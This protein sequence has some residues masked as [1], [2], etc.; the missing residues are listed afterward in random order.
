MCDDQR[1]VVARYRPGAFFGEVPLLLDVPYIL[2]ARGSGLKADRFSRG[3]LLGLA[4]VM[5]LDCRRNFSGDSSAAAEPGGIQP[6]TRKTRFPWTHVRGFGARTKQS[7]ARSRVAVY[8]GEVIQTIQGVAHEL[9]QTLRE[10][11]GTA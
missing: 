5:S 11:I 2:T 6:S 3:R 10:I 1:I 9:H 7:A 8:L 4:A